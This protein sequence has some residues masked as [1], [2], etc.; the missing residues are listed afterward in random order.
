[1]TEQEREIIEIIRGCPDVENA[2]SVAIEIF[3]SL[4]GLPLTSQ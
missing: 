3:T 4:A 1:M 2:L